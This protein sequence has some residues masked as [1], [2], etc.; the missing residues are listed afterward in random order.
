MMMYKDWPRFSL[1]EQATIRDAMAVLDREAM[2]I[3]LLVDKE[4][5]L[6]GVMTDG[7]IR[8]ALLA[9]KTLSSPASEAMNTDPSTGSS[10]DSPLAWRQRMKMDRCRHLPIVDEVG[11]LKGLYYDRNTPFSA[12]TNGVVLMLGGLGMRLR[13]LTENTPKP[14]LNVGGKPILETIVER[15]AEQGFHRFIF[16]IN[17]LGHQIREH[18]GNGRQWG[19][20]IDYVEE[21]Q[22]LGTAGALSLIDSKW[23]NKDFI[24][25]NGDL[26][27]KVDFDAL[28]NFHAQ[29]QSLATLG[30]REYTQQV[31]YGVVE[32]EGEVVQQIVEKPVYRYFVN[33]GIYVL[34]PKA[35]AHLTYNTYLDMPTL[36]DQLMADQQKVGAFPVT[37][38][39]KDIGQIPDF[40]Q[41][42]IDYEIHFTKI[43]R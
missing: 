13:P 19:V 39:W 40:E 11:V 35:I 37:E 9:G 15:F 29:H 43:R 31:P 42:Q 12:K 23:L 6:K 8:R 18:F 27:T 16:C 1:D 38:Y 25:M 34:S 33:A 14:M 7:D 3:V 26:L 41:A 36:I 24:V 21:S 17:Y 22:S 5:K 20:Q 30:V 32:V 10:Q 28:L 4:Q 2:Q